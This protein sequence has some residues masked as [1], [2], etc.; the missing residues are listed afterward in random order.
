MWPSLVQAILA[1]TFPNL[2]TRWY[3]VQIADHQGKLL[4]GSSKFSFEGDTCVKWFLFKW[5]LIVRLLNSMTWYNVVFKIQSELICLLMVAPTQPARH[6]PMYPSILLAAKQQ[7]FHI[8]QYNLT[9]KTEASTVNHLYLCSLTESYQSRWLNWP[10]KRNIY[11]ISSFNFFQEFF[12]YFTDSH[13]F[14]KNPVTQEFAR[15]KQKNN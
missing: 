13:P 5:L 15:L 12:F 11:W 1:E 3:H 14:A 6:C 8:I 4:L 10:F 9:V 2:G 7:H